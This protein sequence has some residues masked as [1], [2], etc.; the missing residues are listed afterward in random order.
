M[1]APLSQFESG[2]TR[3][4]VEEHF[5]YVCPELERRVSLIAAEGYKSYPD[6]TV[7]YAKLSTGRHGLPLANLLQHGRRHLNL[8][9]RGDRSED[10]LAKVAWAIMS[11]MHQETQAT[12][13]PCQH[14]N[15][16]LKP[17]DQ[18]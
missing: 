8:Y 18:K 14:F 15:M 1:S 3:V 11:I 7:P 13:K 4:E 6:T 2:A 5:H 12:D 10:H 17:E 9:L 16:L